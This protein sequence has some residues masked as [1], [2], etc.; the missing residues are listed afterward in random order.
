MPPCQL[1]PT[2]AQLVRGVSFRRTKGLA[3]QDLVKEGLGGKIGLRKDEGG[4]IE[5]GVKL[6]SSEEELEWQGGGKVRL[7]RQ[8]WWEIEV[9]LAGVMEKEGKGQWRDGVGKRD[10]GDR[11]GKGEI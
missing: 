7:E 10:P 9:G 4:L 1:S 11:G 2:S 5:V 3:L 8:G 6:G